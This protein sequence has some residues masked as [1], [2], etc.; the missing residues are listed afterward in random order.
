MYM[1]IATTIIQILFML[2]IF[3]L[4]SATGPVVWISDVNGVTP[5]LGASYSLSCQVTGVSSTINT[6]EWRRDD[7]VLS[8][9]GSTLSFSSL[10]QS[11]A[12]Q[13]TCQVTVNGMTFTSQ[14]REI[15]LTPTG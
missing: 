15:T 5:V 1:Y 6:Y 2:V 9:T 4:F 3:F 11:D 10:S 14:A 12:G 8:E 7:K 13:Y